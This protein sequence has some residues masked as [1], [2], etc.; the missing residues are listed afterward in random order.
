MLPKTNLKGLT[1]G[2]AHN[3]SIFIVENKGRILNGIAG[4]S[5]ILNTKFNDFCYQT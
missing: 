3:T 1:T 4:Y 2:M 5:T